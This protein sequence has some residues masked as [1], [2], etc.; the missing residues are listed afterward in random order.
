LAS[1]QPGITTPS[2][3]PPFALLFPGLCIRQ[4]LLLIISVLSLIAISA[5]SWSAIQVLSQHDAAEQLVWDNVA[6]EQ[7]LSLNILLARERGFTA[8]MLANSEYYKSETRQDLLTLREK[9][10][11]SLRLLKG[12]I[13]AR[14]SLLGVVAINDQLAA[15][16]RNLA[17][18]RQKVDLSLGHHK[19]T[20]TANG[21]IAAVTRYIEDVYRISRTISAPVNED[22]QAAS[23]GIASKEIFFALSEDLGRD[24]ALLS[25]VIAEHRSLLPSEYEQLSNYQY[26]IQAAFNKIDRMLLNFPRTSAITL[27]RLELRHTYKREYQ[28]LRND[29]IQSSRAG[30]TY[31]VNTVEWFGR[32]TKGVDAVLRLSNAIDLHINSDINTIKSNADNTMM[33][34]F[35]VFVLVMIIFAFAFIVIHRR[36]LVPLGE[37]EFSAK[38]I[39]NGDFSRA[40]Q[41]SGH[42]E[43]CKVAEAFEIMRVNL[44]DDRR[45]RSNKAED[46]LRKLSTAIEQS[47]SSILMTDT[48]GVIEYVNPQFYRTTGYGVDE[49]I[50]KNSSILESAETDAET[51]ADLWSTIKQGLVWHGELLNKKKNGE[52]YWEMVSISPVRN[53][54]EEITHYISIQHDISKRKALEE[55]LNFMAYHDELTELPNRALLADRFTQVV[56]H[57]QRHEGAKVALLMMDLNRF[58]MINDSLGH[59][60][61]DQLLIEV[62]KRLKHAMRSCDTLSRYGGDEFVMLIED[63]TNIED[64]VEIVKRLKGALAAPF[65]ISDQELHVSGSMGISVWPDDGVDMDSLLTKAD[66]AMYHA[67]DEGGEDFQ[68]F[69]DEMN[70]K[71]SQ[72]LHLENDLRKAIDNQEFELYYQPQ[73]CLTTGR[74]TGAE[75]L[76]RWNHSELGLVPPIQFIPLAEDTALIKPIGQWVLETACQQLIKWK[77]AGQTEMSMAVNVSVRQLEDPHFIAGLTAALSESGIDPADLEIEIT[78][79]AVMSQPEK[80]LAVLDAIKRLGVKLALDDFGTGY[81][82]LSYLRDFPFDKLKIDRSFIKDIVEKP[83]DVVI[84][85]AISTMAHTL[86]MRVLAEGVETDIQASHV[87]SCFCDEMQGYLI[88]RPV[89]AGEFELL[90]H[91]PHPVFAELA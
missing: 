88:S 5:I 40:A 34:F 83:E 90:F 13:E 25:M 10:D 43:F 49:V 46:E 33:A 35:A 4:I 22:G 21:W 87:R 64:L 18:K 53:R 82:S 62:A 84:A 68:F 42:D 75:A 78:E 54:D 56:A 23:Y 26:G 55:R 16:S 57:A 76:I 70:K 7:A 66:T 63:V 38:T 73:V 71:I 41:I 67:K 8:G 44:I 32:A 86:N 39:G 50:G 45:E 77:K 36:I 51:F 61:G 24:R 81:S 14:P 27:A 29:V 3:A 28:T 79:S 1:N 6:V 89:P 19:V 65:I 12:S 20:I 47:V 37:L 52:L 58:K 31:P 72:R 80:M 59:S 11:Q 2:A 74:L 48:T 17:D 60:A 91:Q 15:V 69:T 30:R 9:T 85:Q